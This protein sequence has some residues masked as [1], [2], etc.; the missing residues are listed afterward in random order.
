MNNTDT[1]WLSTRQAAVRL[2][3]APRDLYRLID[4]GSLPAYKY[5]R[6]IRLKEAEVDA[7]RASHPQ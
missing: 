4:A 3:I 7:Y 6:D 5:G 2:G 1:T